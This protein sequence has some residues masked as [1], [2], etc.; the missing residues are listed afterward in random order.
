MQAHEVNLTHIESRPSKTHAGCYEIL[1]EC[2][3]DSTQH[4]IED[5]NSVPWFPRRI[6]DID[7]FANRILSYGAELDSDHPG[8]K[9]TTY[10][11]RRKYFADIAFNFRQYVKCSSSNYPIHFERYSEC[12]SGDKIPRIE[13]TAQEIETWRTVYNVSESKGLI[14]YIRHH[15]APKYTPEPFTGSPSNS[16]FACNM[17]RR[18][19]TVQ[20]QVAPFEPSVTSTTE[21]PITEYQPKYFLAESFASAKEKLKT[22][23]ATIPRSFQP[24]VAPFEPSVTSTTDYPITEYQPKYFLAESFASAKEKLKTWAATIPRS[25]QVRYNAYTQR[26]EVLDRVSELQRM[27]REIKSKWDAFWISNSLLYKVIIQ[28]EITT[29][30][31]ALGK[32]S[33]AN[34]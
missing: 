25:F 5:V 3:E 16:E 6:A 24:Q 23:A 10:R 19:P 9:D 2:G 34:K 18:K 13:Y 29:L 15:S 14:I 17:E 27:V 1:V 33:V 12:F 30:E 7:Q 20:P 4:K 28:G 31:D 32:V 11:E 26:I 8:F 22:W 21:Y